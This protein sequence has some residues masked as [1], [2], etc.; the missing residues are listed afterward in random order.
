M[1]DWISQRQ[2]RLMAEGTEL[3]V[4]RSDGS[5]AIEPKVSAAR[6]AAG[7][8]ALIVAFL[9]K[10]VPFLAGFQDTVLEIVT[11]AILAG[12]VFLATWWA[13]WRARHVQRP[14]Q[15]GTSVLPTQGEKLQ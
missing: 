8:S 6:L 15:A 11:D 1:V 10:T 9:I 3:Q 5:Y 2:A 7:L 13:G 14:N 4:P 12:M